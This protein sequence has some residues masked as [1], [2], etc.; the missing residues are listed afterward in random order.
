MSETANTPDGLGIDAAAAQFA[1]IL[2]GEEPKNEETSEAQPTEEV[3]SEEP[4]EEQEAGTEEVESE[5]EA[6]ED[7]DEPAAPR[8]F[9][10]KVD[11]EEVEVTEDDL[12]KGYSRTADYTRKTQALAE[13]RKSFEAEQQAV[14]QERAEYAKV[15]SQLQA[16]LQQTTAQEPDWDALYDHDPIEASKLERKWKSYKEQQAAVRA[17]QDRVAEMERGE[18][19]KALR[20]RLQSE[21]TK[22]LEAIPEWKDEAKAKEGRA[23]LVTYG[24]SLG[25]S[26]EELNAVYD[27]R[28]VKVLADAA[29]YNDLKAKKATLQPTKTH[30]KQAGSSSAN[31]K[32]TSATTKAKQR[33]AK[34]GSVKDAA[35][36]FKGLI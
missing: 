9:K 6:P 4:A 12:V 31:V 1:S 2:Y 15:L 34:T 18:Q 19:I 26:D 17:E 36:I 27:S 30:V 23:K 35:A 5:E 3:E 29:A 20:A 21:Q 33:L 10:V 7:D 13:Q 16:Q 32:Q 22:V 8:T 14:L 25:F 28:M 24:K 11:G